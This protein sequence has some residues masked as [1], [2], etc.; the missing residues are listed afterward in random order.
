[1]T[2]AASTTTHDSKRK[3]FLSTQHKKKKSP[4]NK[5][6]KTATKMHLRL[7]RTLCAD[8]CKKNDDW[9]AVTPVFESNMIRQV[10]LCSDA[11]G[12]TSNKM[13][14]QNKPQNKRRRHHTMSHKNNNKNRQN[15]TEARH[16]VTNSH[17]STIRTQK[18]RQKR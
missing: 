14:N 15:T 9:L 13:D 10:Q 2:P 5:T 6:T 1:M 8:G 16:Q 18:D 3:G 12:F 4:H 17:N 11:Q 7:C